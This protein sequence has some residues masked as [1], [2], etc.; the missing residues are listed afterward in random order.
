ME[1]AAHLGAALEVGDLAGDGRAPV[2]TDDGEGEGLGEAAD[3][4][5]DLHHQLARGRHY[6][7][8]RPVPLRQRR[9]QQQQ[10]LT[11]MALQ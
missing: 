5:A 4:L 8:Y 7:R 3:V 2:G 6:Q 1:K 9:L 11:S 10:T